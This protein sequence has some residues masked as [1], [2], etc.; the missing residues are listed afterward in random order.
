M[1]ASHTFSRHW[2]LETR[3]HELLG[4]DLGEGISR[5]VLLHGLVVFVLWDG[6][7]LLAAGFPTTTVFSFYLLPP[8]F[9]TAYGTKRSAAY[10]RRRNFLV[11]GVTVNY[12][13]NGVRPVTG[14]GRIPAPRLG[15]RL[16]AQR[17]GER[18]PKLAQLPAPGAAFAPVD[19]RDL[20]EASGNPAHIRHRVRLYG[21][22]AVAKARIKAFKRTRTRRKDR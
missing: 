14:R 7:L 18:F 4:L 22:D 8:I 1:R 5:K 3:Q 6:F 15:W 9:I 19:G 16:R 10:W 11:W 12:L 21:P 13:I 2:D 20:A 17:L